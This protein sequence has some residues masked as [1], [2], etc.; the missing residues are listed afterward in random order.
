MGGGVRE[1]HELPPRLSSRSPPARTAPR[2]AVDV[3]LT[4]EYETFSP[5]FGLFQSMRARESCQSPARN[6]RI[7]DTRH[8]PPAPDSNFTSS[9]T[10]I[11]DHAHG[12]ALTN[13]YSHA[14]VQEKFRRRRLRLLSRADLGDH[15]PGVLVLY[16]VAFDAT[17]PS[18]P[19]LLLNAF[20]G[21]R[22]APFHRSAG[23]A[24][25]GRTLPYPGCGRLACRGSVRRAGA[26]SACG[27]SCW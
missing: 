8:G 4:K 5:G 15:I 9:F 23:G 7:L 10:C 12:H 3:P 22:P 24:S 1:A 13:N 14:P 2:R 25:T 18:L 20:Q 21:R 16:S 6:S 26:S 11:I 27:S 17:A 19:P